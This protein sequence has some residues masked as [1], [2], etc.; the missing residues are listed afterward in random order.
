M[1]YADDLFVLC[2][3]KSNMRKVIQTIKTW[4]IENN[5]NLNESKSGVM[6]FLPRQGGN[7]TLNIGQ[8]FEGIP[9]VACYKYLD[10]WIDQKLTMELQ[11]EHIK[12]KSD[13]ISIKM[14]HLLKRISLDYRKNLWTILIRPLFDQIS[15]LYYCER[16]KCHKEKVDTLLRYTFRKFTLLKKNVPTYIVD[17]LMDYKM[18]ERANHNITITKTKWQNRLG[19]KLYVEENQVDDEKKEKVRILPKELLQFINLQVAKCIKKNCQ[20]RCSKEHLET[21]H[22]I[23]VPTYKETIKIIER[24]SEEARYYKMNRKDA[25]AYV[26]EFLQ[27]HINKIIDLLNSNSTSIGK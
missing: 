13:W 9:I 6:E 12:S 8:E 21:E 23:I 20:S 7:L 17:D 26:E 4:S 25:L 1:G 10:V 2:Y 22:Q 5:L 14:W 3:S 15:I 16:A 18:D 27:T 24:K 11:I 19:K